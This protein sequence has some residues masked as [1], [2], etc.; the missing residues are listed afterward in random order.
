MSIFRLGRDVAKTITTTSAKNT[1]EVAKIA[2]ALKTATKAEDKT[3]ILNA[4]VNGNR[5]NPGL[6]NL[7]AEL[8]GADKLN[9]RNSA[10]LNKAK[11]YKQP[12]LKAVRIN[13][14]DGFKPFV[15][16]DLSP[17]D[18]KRILRLSG[19]KKFWNNNLGLPLGN[20]N[21]YDSNEVVNAFNKA[22]GNSEVSKLL[23]GNPVDMDS[24]WKTI[25]NLL[26]SASWGS[27]GYDMGE[28]LNRFNGNSENGNSDSIWKNPY[29]LG[30]AAATARAAFPLA[31]LIP[32]NSNALITTA[33]L[34]VPAAVAKTVNH[35]T[36]PNKVEN[37]SSNTDSNTI[38]A[39]ALSN[40]NNGDAPLTDGLW[41]F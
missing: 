2:N 32:R 11:D 20:V 36:T 7:I 24:V 26:A 6:L 12:E 37:N 27:A 10:V 17:E 21:T 9:A 29:V 40:S 5:G 22:I 39:N 41:D 31:R 1:D 8:E 38:T 30:I 4:A 13:T 28:V 14:E 23:I 3:K 35:V 25:Y 18:V 15:P 34:V 33:D 16:R 19:E